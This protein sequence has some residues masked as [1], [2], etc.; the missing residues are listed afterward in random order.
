LVFPNSGPDAPESH[1]M[2]GASFGG[3]FCCHGNTFLN[4]VVPR[5]CDS[6]ESHRKQVGS[7]TNNDAFHCSSS[8]LHR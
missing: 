3:S 1:F 2:N 4:V 7:V 5:R 8:C 6:P